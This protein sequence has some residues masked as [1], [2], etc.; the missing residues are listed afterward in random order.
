MIDKLEKPACGIHDNRE[1]VRRTFI[2]RASDS[3]DNCTDHE[4]IDSWLNKILGG[5]A[6]AGILG[7]L[8]LS[9]VW[10]S[11]SEMQEGQLS[12]VD[13]FNRWQTKV[14]KSVDKM[15]INSTE[16][17]KS[18]NNIEKSTA[19][20]AKEFQINSANAK[21]ERTE[22]KNR[23]KELEALIHKI[24]EKLDSLEKQYEIE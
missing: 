20:M 3:C 9:I 18:M 4:R 10:V 17:N 15:V 5:L 14:D 11:R 12:H 23:I 2:R 13:V 21:L 8:M 7:T 1:K 16:M 6:L 22:N 24:L 19:V